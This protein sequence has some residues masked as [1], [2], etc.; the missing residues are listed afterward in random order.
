MPCKHKKSSRKYR[1][2]SESD[3]SSEEE[4]K[5]KHKS[6]P[7]VEV[8]ETKCEVKHSVCDTT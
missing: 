7:V 2:D 4:K 5:E 1:S 3:Y 6:K 8:K